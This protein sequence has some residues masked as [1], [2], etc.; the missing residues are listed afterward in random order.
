ME[1]TITIQIMLQMYNR[2]MNRKK[3]FNETPFFIG[4]I[5]FSTAI[6]RK[7]AALTFVKAARYL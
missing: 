3:Y 4:E 2:R 1:P 6:A 5:A 7:N